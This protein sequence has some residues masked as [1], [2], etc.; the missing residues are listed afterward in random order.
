[1]FI[2]GGAFDPMTVGHE[3][4]IRNLVN[5]VQTLAHQE[6]VYD[7]DGKAVPKEELDHIKEFATIVYVTNNDE[8][9]YS[10]PLDN[11]LRIVEKVVG[12]LEPLTI[13]PQTERMA[14]TLKTLIADTIKGDG[15]PG[16]TEENININLV[17]GYDEWVSLKHREWVESDWLLNRCNFLVVD[18][19]DVRSYG[20]C[21]IRVT[22]S[23]IAIPVPKDSD[24]RVKYVNWKV[25][26]VS[27]TEVRR[28]MKF[29]PLYD[30]KDVP[31]VVAMELGRLRLLGQ[32][33]QK[34][35]D[36]IEE[37]ELKAYAPKQYPKPSVTATTILQYMNK[38]LLVRRRGFP[39]HDYWCFPG[40]F[41]EPHEDIEKVALREVKEETKLDCI[42]PS[43]V[44]QLGVYTPAD[45]R[46]TK[47]DDYWMY[48]VGLMVDLT[49]RAFQQPIASD[50]A[51]DA[52]WVDIEEVKN[53]PLAFHHKK[54]F[55]AFLKRRE[56]YRERAQVGRIHEILL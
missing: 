38:V 15:Y 53:I 5:Y 17:M 11:R 42:E 28:A 10:I 30:G 33:S 46:N 54:I 56:V 21:N 25:P 37:T 9:K 26:C 14:A 1:M 19:P 12:D 35:Y 18:R 2:Y 27:S 48:D 39:Y 6:T 50:D 22:Q 7:L 16:L 23:D 29:N 49:G 47:F 8:K 24:L 45:P 41:A 34:E 4:I 43:E 51:K 20:E 40:G 44:I 36:Q 52:M 13:L 32:D 31:I 55:E 3:G